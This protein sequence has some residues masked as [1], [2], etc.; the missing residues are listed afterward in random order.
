[1]FFKSIRGL[2]SKDMRSSPPDLSS[3]YFNRT[4]HNEVDIRFTAA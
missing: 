2:Y 4:F 1:M 3:M